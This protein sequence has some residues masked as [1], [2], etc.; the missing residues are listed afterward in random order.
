MQ[1]LH[2]L[3]A[4]IA[5]RNPLSGFLYLF[6][7]ASTA[8]GLFTVFFKTRKIQPNGFKW[9]IYRNEALFAVVNLFFSGILLGG[10]IAFL[11]SHGL[12]KVSH[13]PVGWWVIAGEYLLFFIGFDTWFYWLHR[14]MHKEPIYTLVHKIHHK[15]TA[16]NILTTLSVNPLES[17]VNGGFMP[18]FRAVMTVHAPSQ[19]LMSLTIGFMGPYVHSGHEF[20]PRWWNRSWATKWFITA[21]FHDQHHKYFNWN[22][23]GFTTVW[24]Y[25]CGTQR[26]RY[27][28]DFRKL[29]ERTGKAAPVPI[30]DHGAAQAA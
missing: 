20:L 19:M 11:R 8:N 24:D 27:E 9:K 10:L 30:E 12:I 2:E 15:S 28:D 6:L 17:L 16:P 21:T 18:L 29:K 26:K 3:W 14:L 23:G 5:G 4:L 1:F 22:F 7:G 13:D 25:I